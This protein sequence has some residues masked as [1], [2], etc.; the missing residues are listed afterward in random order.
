MPEPLSYRVE[1]ALRRTAVL[2]EDTAYP[3]WDSARGAIGA[4]E[5][6]EE[7]RGLLADVSGLLTAWLIEDVQISQA[8]LEDVL[9]VA[10]S[11]VGRRA[12]RFEPRLR[13]ILT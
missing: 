4:L 8:L 6:I 9:G 10:A 13:Q 12:R 1:Q 11:N 3:G 5:S 2:A 7:M